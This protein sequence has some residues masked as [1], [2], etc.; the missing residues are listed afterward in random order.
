M[1]ELV[2]LLLPEFYSTVLSLALLISRGATLGGGWEF[3]KESYL[4]YIL[5]GI[6]IGSTISLFMSLHK[7]GVF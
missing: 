2:I 6:L 3:P 7:L 1:N 5:A 4:D